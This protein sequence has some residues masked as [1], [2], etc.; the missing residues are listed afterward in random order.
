MRGRRTARDPPAVGGE[1]GGGTRWLIA[2]ATRALGRALAAGT[3]A[4]TGAGGQG[5]QRGALQPPPRPRKRSRSRPRQRP[6]RRPHPAWWT[7]VRRSRGL[8]GSRLGPPLWSSSCGYT[9]SS[10]WTSSSKDGTPSASRRARMQ[11]ITPPVAAALAELPE[12]MPAALR[13]AGCC[14]G[15]D[16]Q[17]EWR[18]ESEGAA[19]ARNE[20]ACSWR[21]ASAK[22][23]GSRRRRAAVA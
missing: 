22:S 1:A 17:M 3:R 11:R 23:I 20:R 14:G 2:S 13:V 15:H 4:R 12:T 16:E 9:A 19:R 10:T 8:L 21:V 6:R 7:L 18:Q 5:R